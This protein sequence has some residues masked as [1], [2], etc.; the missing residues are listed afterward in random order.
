M[1][2]AELSSAAREAVS[3]KDLRK[4]LLKYGVPAALLLA[5]V[6]TFAPRQRVSIKSKEEVRGS[7]KYFASLALALKSSTLRNM[8]LSALGV[9]YLSNRLFGVRAKRA[10]PSFFA[11]IWGL[12]Y[13][14]HVAE[15]PHVWFR[16]TYYNTTLVEKSKI[17]TTEFWPV[18]WLFNRHA[19]TVTCYVLSALEWLW[20]QPI[21]YRRETLPCHDPPNEQYLDWAYFGDASS[22]LPGA[23][24]HHGP[25]DPPEGEPGEPSGAAPGPAP[26]FGPE[27][28]GADEDDNARSTWQTPIV[29]CIH[30]LGDNKDI[31]YIK[32]FARVCLRKGWRVVVWSYWRFMFEES[33][34][35][36]IVIDHL[37]TQCPRAPITA[38]AWS[39]GSYYLTR[40]LQKAGADKTPLV[41]AICQSPCLDF[42]Q[43]VNDVTANENTTYPLFLLGQAHTCVRRH[44]RNDKRIK[45]KAAFNDLLL[46]LDPMMLF[47]RFSTMLPEP[48]PDDTGFGPAGFTTDTGTVMERV[49]NA[50]HY[51]TRSIDEMHKIQVPTLL[52]HAEDDPVVSSLHVDW[53]KLESNRK[54]IVAH[55]RRGGHCA[56]HEGLMPVGDTWGD[57]VTSNFISAVIEMHSQTHFLVELVRNAMA[58][59]NF[60]ARPG[61]RRA[62]GFDP[63]S[64]TRITSASDL[65][66]MGQARLTVGHNGVFGT[67]RQD[68]NRE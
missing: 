30:G 15:T 52:L 28:G 23:K 4:A 17:T 10:F 14:F 65:A 61:M 39:A 9:T 1:G 40:Y 38:V 18:F 47:N 3:R 66:S 64:I 59:E 13:F 7:G 51:T 58:L 16:R 62:Q 44:V 32:R 36:K 19:Q 68:S 67:S 53:G 49:Q 57:R 48:I 63:R 50:A 22:I 31:P 5:A 43:A 37:H 34:D 55:T 29:L 42:V 2:V 26:G 24:E 35:L 46:E 6:R 21:E 11:T 27:L 12:I 20:A 41:S 56:W 33:R 25:E 60:S 54:I 45:D 8:L